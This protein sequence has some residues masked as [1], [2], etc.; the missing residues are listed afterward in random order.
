MVMG[1]LLCREDGHEHILCTVFLG[2]KSVLGGSKLHATYS[3]MNY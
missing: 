1:F 3:S 2:L